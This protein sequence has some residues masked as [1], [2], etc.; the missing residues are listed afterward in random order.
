MNRIWI[1]LIPRA[2][3]IL[4]AIA[5]ILILLAPAW[6]IS[7]GDPGPGAPGPAE[8]AP[9]EAAPRSVSKPPARKQPVPPQAPAGMQL[10]RKVMSPSGKLAIQYLRDRQ[11]GIRQIA[12][13]D[14]KN[15]ANTTVLAQY[16]RNAWVVL[17]PD[18]EWIVLNSRERL[19]DSTA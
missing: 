17:S 9:S 13:Q 14:A 15:P 10:V 11:Q 1:V 8:A 4:A 19:R 3:R 7:L 2:A 18:D 6:T 12:L 16:K 5:S